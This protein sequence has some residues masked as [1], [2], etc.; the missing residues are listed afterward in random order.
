MSKIRPVVYAVN[1]LV[2]IYLDLSCSTIKTTTG[3]LKTG[4]LL[5]LTNQQPKYGMMQYKQ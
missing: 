3:L 1:Y 4:E 5:P 2:F